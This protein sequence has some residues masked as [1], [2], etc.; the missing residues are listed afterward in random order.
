MEEKVTCTSEEE[1]GKLERE[2][3]VV[4]SVANFSSGD[5]VTYTLERG[6][7]WSKKFKEL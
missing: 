4:V 3:Y 6:S 1:K 7:T 2:G 5:G